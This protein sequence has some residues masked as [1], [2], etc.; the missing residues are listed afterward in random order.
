M[1]KKKNE[2]YE[3]YIFGAG[4]FFALDSEESVGYCI[5]DMPEFLSYISA[6]ECQKCEQIIAYSGEAELVETDEREMGKEYF[7]HEENLFECPKCKQELTIEV[8]FNEYAGSWFFE[9]DNEGADGVKVDG[10]EWLAEEHFRSEMLRGEKEKLEGVA[11]M[12]TSRVKDLIKQTN[13]RRMY[14]LIVEGKDDRAVWDQFLL[15]E[16]VPLEDVDISVYGDGG[17]SEAIRLASLFR[18]KKLRLIP[19]KLVIDS[20]GKMDAILDGLKKKQ[21]DKKRYHVLEEK[22]IESYILDEEAIGQIISVEP[23]KVKRFNDCLKGAAGK[24]RLE[25]IFAEFTKSKPDDLVKGLVARAM[26]VT[27]KEIFSIIK[28]IR[29]SLET[30]ETDDMENY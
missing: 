29:D 12:L 23:D 1:N 20:D 16:G 10:L 30:N 6:F 21:I 26:K 3:I 28:E 7:Y 17:A 25:R 24:E 2:S 14:V 4:H 11:S 27:P 22:E 5:E 8:D 19:H 15:K 9:D 18:G 13:E